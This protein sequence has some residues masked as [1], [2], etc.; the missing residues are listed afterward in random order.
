[1][2]IFSLN[3]INKLRIIN[4]LSSYTEVLYKKIT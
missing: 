3:R 1:L 4:I 2:K